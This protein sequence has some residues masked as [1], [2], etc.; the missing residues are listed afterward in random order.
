M[1][2]APEKARIGEIE[3]PL[4]EAAIIRLGL[5]ADRRL[6]GRLLREFT[7]DEIEARERR[8]NTDREVRE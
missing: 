8:V 4:S 6:F 3:P 5:E 7:R 1:T 2:D